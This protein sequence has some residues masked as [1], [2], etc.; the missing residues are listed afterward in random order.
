M[1]TS[2]L[3]PVILLIVSGAALVRILLPFFSAILWAVILALLLLPSY[4]RLLLKMRRRHNA[5][6]AIVLLGVVLVGVLPFA[7]L[8]TALASQA[9]DVYRLVA[10]GEWRVGDFIRK[11][12]LYLP[13]WLVSLLQ[14]LGI[15]NGDVLM[16]RINSALSEGSQWVATQAL[17]IGLD[18][19]GFASSLG[20]ALYLGYFFL[21]DGQQISR[22]FW[23]AVPLL[24]AQKEVFRSRFSAV[25]R[26]T[27]KGSVSIALIQG[28]LGGLAFWFLEVKGA[29]LWGMLMALASLLPVIGT[30]LVWLP[31]VVYLLLAGE[32]WKALQLAVFSVAVIGFTDNLLRPILVGRTAQ[33]PDYVVMITTL[34]GI[35]VFGINGIVIG[36]LI[37]AMFFAAWHLNLED[38]PGTPPAVKSPQT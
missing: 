36:P 25:I 18:T 19:F 10:S 37:A 26:A 38:S 31:V 3:L 4:R 8:T 30:A 6:A 15:G 29:L 27:I 34:G 21:R 17:S 33:M 24:P 28:S 23:R 12:F 7:L 2:Q 14:Q 5:A 9:S 13:D 32:G 20:V 22:S 1:K 11:V 35:A 16:R